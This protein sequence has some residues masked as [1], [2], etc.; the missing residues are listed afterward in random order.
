MPAMTPPSQPKQP[1]AARPQPSPAD[2]SAHQGRRRLLPCRVRGTILVDRSWY[3][4]AFHDTQVDVL[5][6]YLKPGTDPEAVRARIRERWGEREGLRA[7]TRAELHREVKDQ[8]R[9]VYHLAYAQ[10]FVVGLVA[11]LGV[12]SALFIS[13]LQRRRELG[14]LRAVGASRAQVLGTVAAEASL[15]GAAGA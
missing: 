6:V 12:V 11:L 1:P 15:M 9:R 5:D 4:K 8:V 14:L 2:R 13:V 7:A 10:E 3:A